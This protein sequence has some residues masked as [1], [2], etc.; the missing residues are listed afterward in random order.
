MVAWGSCT[1]AEAE[2]VARTGL[3]YWAARGGALVLTTVISVGNLVLNVVFVVLG[4]FVL[5]ADAGAAVLQGE[6]GGAGR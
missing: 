5:R 3:P 6:S 4:W 1:E 2:A